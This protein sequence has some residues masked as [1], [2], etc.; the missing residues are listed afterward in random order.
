[1]YQVPPHTH[2]HRL[3]TFFLLSF[4]WG[5]GHIAQ[6]DLEFLILLLHLLS[7]RIIGIC[8]HIW[9]YEVLGIKPTP[10]KDS[11]K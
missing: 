8:H 7:A 10:G 1:M 4:I 6:D 9:F 3:D 2:T 5:S 11:S